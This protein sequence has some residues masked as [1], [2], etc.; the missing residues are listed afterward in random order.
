M[1]EGQ[2]LTPVGTVKSQIQYS[3]NETQWEMI[4]RVVEHS[5]IS[6]VKLL[7]TISIM[8]NSL[9]SIYCCHM[10]WERAS[11]ASSKLNF[12][13]HEWITAGSQTLL[14]I[15]VTHSVVTILNRCKSAQPHWKKLVCLLFT[16]HA[17]N[18]VSVMSKRVVTLI[19]VGDHLTDVFQVVM[20][21]PFPTV[22]IKFILLLSFFKKVSR[23][24][25]QKLSC[26]SLCLKDCCMS[27]ERFCMSVALGKISNQ[28]C[29]TGICDYF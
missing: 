26:N 6:L 1:W 28:N 24:H 13:A 12:S 16:F 18:V 2:Y 29:W 17:S 19:S 9:Q 15:L 7:L 23:R 4:P 27:D 22:D 21:R 10:H 25:R 3:W 8:C 11:W 5:E 14:F 20:P